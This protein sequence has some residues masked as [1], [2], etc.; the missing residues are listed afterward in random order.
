[1]AS[2]AYTIHKSSD[3]SQGLETKRRY[4][5]LAKNKTSNMKTA[6]SLNTGLGF[7]DPHHWPNK[8]A[9]TWKTL[10][11]IEP[12]RHRLVHGFYNK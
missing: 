2:F 5:V 3:A 10:V 1:V 6:A 4:K 9:K 8:S 12:L 7:K 11:K